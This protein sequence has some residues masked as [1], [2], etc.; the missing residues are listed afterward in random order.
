MKQ[1]MIYIV[2]IVS[3]SMLVLASCASGPQ[4]DPVFRDD[5]PAVPPSSG[6]G[7]QMPA[8]Q[9]STPAPTPKGR[10]LTGKALYGRMSGLSY[11]GCYPD[12]ST[13]AETTLSDGRLRDDAGGGSIVG[14]WNVSGDSLCFDQNNQQTC[15]LTYEDNRGLHFYLKESG[16]YIASTVCPMDM[17]AG[18]SQPVPPSQPQGPAVSGMKGNQLRGQDLYSQMSGLSYAGCYPDG[19][20]FKETTLANGQ[21]RNDENGQTSASWS[22]SGDMLCYNN[23]GADQPFCVYVSRDRQGLHFYEKESGQYVASTVCPMQP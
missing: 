20:R 5:A 1:K 22:V 16:A 11:N 4:S 10:Q 17:S 14:N 3:A 2:V 6:G 15:V 23:P 19:T 18:P 13:F 12:G 7:A 21:V 8:Q 9:P